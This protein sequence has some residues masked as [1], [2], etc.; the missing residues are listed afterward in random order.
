MFKKYGKEKVKLKEVVFYKVNLRQANFLNSHFI[1]CK[2][3]ECDLVDANFSGS[4]FQDTC[5][6]TCELTNT[7]FSSGQVNGL[8]LTQ[9]ELAVIFVQEEE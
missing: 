2:F 3:L 9:E 8:G 6:E 7:I 1:N 4:S 5:F